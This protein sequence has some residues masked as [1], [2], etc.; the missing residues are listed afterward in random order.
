[1]R[2][3]ERAAGFFAAGRATT[4]TVLALRAAGFRTGTAT[5]RSDFA[6][7]ARGR[8]G[9][10]FCGRRLRTF[11][12]TTF[13]RAASVV[14]SPGGPLNRC[15]SDLVA[16]GVVSPDLGHADVQFGA[17]LPG[18]V[19]HRCGYIEMKRGLD[20]RER[21]PLRHRLEVVDGFDCFHLDNAEQLTVS[22]RGVKDEVRVPRRR[23]DRHRRSLLVTRIDR[24]V[25]LS[26]VFRLKQT[27]DPIVLEL[28]A[29]RPHEYWAQTTPPRGG[30]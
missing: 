8:P 29:D 4:F 19:H 20:A 1:L 22:F 26:L 13:F 15:E 3:V 21:R 25:E 28:L 27:N 11:A 6:G 10:G 23:T 30:T 14:V 24:D 2:L 17:E 7:A 16:D 12:V 18:H 5:R 9:F